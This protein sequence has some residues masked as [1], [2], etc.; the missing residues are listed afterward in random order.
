MRKLC[1]APFVFGDYTNYVPFYIYSILKSYPDYY[2]KVFVKGF[3]TQNQKIALSKLHEKL[4]NNF[5]II[6]NYFNN[7][8]TDKG[9]EKNRCLRWLIPS[10]EFKNFEN[11]YMGDID[12]LIIKE[13]PSLLDSHLQHC[14]KTNLPYSN[15]IRKSTKRLTGLH[16]IKTKEYFNKMNSLINYYIINNDKIPNNLKDEKFLYSMIKKTIGFGNLKQV[17]FRPHHGLHLGFFRNFLNYTTKNLNSYKIIH[18][19]K[20]SEYIASYFNL[21]GKQQILNLFTDPLFNEI[22]K[23]IK[24]KTIISQFRF[25]KKFF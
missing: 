18:K 5:E 19:M 21:T 3:L 23:I 13:N 12:I 14:T 7:L 10:K 9:I 17:T 25:I 1:F 15:T 4:S 2:I 11:V 20:I 16:F 8:L 6:E 22:S 24:Y